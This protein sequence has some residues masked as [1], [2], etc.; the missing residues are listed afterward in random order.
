VWRQKGPNQPGKLV[1]Y[2]V[3]NV[4]EHMSFLEMLDVLNEQIVNEGKEEPI[5]F[6]YDCREGICGACSLMI[7]GMA[8]GPK[9]LTCSCQLHMRNYSEGDTIVV[10]PF[11]AASFPVIKDL[12]VDRSSFDRIVEAGGYV[13]VETGSAPDANTIPVGKS[14]VDTA[15]DYATFIGCGSCHPVYPHYS[16]SLFNRTKLAQLKRLPQGEN[17]RKK[18]TVAIVEQMDEEDFGECLNYP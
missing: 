12:V 3:N 16:S 10:E 11:R 4:N 7:D 15:F 17:G 5:E 1:D 6:D 13:S 9:A 8:H 18:R 14:V 2:D